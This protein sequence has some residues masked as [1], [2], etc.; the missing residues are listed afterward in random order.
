MSPNNP[1]IESNESWHNP[2]DQKKCGFC[3]GYRITRKYYSGEVVFKSISDNMVSSIQ[4]YKYENTSGDELNNNY[5]F[6]LS[7][8]EKH[9]LSFDP[10]LFQ[11]IY[12]FGKCLLDKVD[13]NEYQSTLIYNLIG[14]WL[15]FVKQI[16]KDTIWYNVSAKNYRLNSSITNLSKLVRPFLLC[17]L[18]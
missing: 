2:P 17:N 8:F 18:C 15:Y 5:E 14:R 12:N 11:Y 4:K 6:L 16:E 1:I 13:N 3:Q 10:A 9:K 7:Q